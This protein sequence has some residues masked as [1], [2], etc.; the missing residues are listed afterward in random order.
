MIARRSRHYAGT[1]YLKRGI[2]VHGKAANDCEV[3]Q[4]SISSGIIVY[5]WFHYLCFIFMYMIIFYAT[6]L[7]TTTA[8]TTT[9]LDRPAWG[10]L[11]L[12]L[13]QL[14]ADARLH[15]DLLVPGDLGHHAQAPDPDQPGGPRL[16][17]HWGKS[18]V[19]IL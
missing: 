15:P 10:Q 17:R 11:P 1:R 12:P 13:L 16:P 4:V 18:V 7:T 6:M 3:E 8:T 19:Y 5:I 9:P 14:P 2:N